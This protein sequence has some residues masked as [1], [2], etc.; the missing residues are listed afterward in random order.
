MLDIF[1]DNFWFEIQP[2]DFEEQRQVNIEVVNYA[3][4][5]GR[6]VVATTD[7]H[8]PYEEWLDTQQVVKMMSTK[9]SFKKQ[10]KELEKR[11]AQNPTTR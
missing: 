8:S 6:P 5:F 10:E 7:A 3:Q 1:G 4:K 9:T 11:R 2:H